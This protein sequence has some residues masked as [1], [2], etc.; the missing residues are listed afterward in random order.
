MKSLQEKFILDQLN[1]YDGCEIRNKHIDNLN[2]VSTKTLSRILN[3]K[4]SNGS[5]MK[6]IFCLFDT[7][8]LSESKSKTRE[9]GLYNL[10]SNIQKWIK[11]MDKLPVNSKEGFV[12]TANFFSPDIEVIVKVPQKTNGNE[13]K[14]REYFIGIK[15]INRLRSLIPTFVYTLGA[16]LCNKSP[17]KTELC[18]N[19]LCNNDLSKNTAF[20]LYEKI[21]G[22]SIHT[23]LK[24]D[25]INFDQWLVIFFQLLLGL[26]VAQREVRFTHFDLHT[27]NVMIRKNDAYSYNV[28]LDM[29]TY[30]II[31]PEFIPVIID[32]G[33]ASSYIDTRYVGSFDYMS[34]GML[35]F[36]IPG[37]DMYKFMTFCAKKTV[38]KELKTKIVSLF[39][40]YEND[41]PYNILNDSEGIDK[42]VIAYC[43]E[44]TF[45][46]VANYT[47][48]MLMNWIWE[49]KEYRSILQPYISI[50][51][52]VQYIPIQYSN[53]I[54]EYDN[55]FNY[56][57]EGTDKAVE[58]I[59]NSIRLKSSYV[60]NKYNIMILEK[61]NKD[62][63][64]HKLNSKIKWMNKFISKYKSLLIF[65]DMAM[66]EKVFDI[67]IPKQI[68]LDK[69]FDNLLAIKLQNSKDKQQAVNYLN[70]LLSYQENL[71]PYLQFYFTILEL[72]LTDT[73]TIWIKK[74][75]QSDIYLFHNKNVVQNERCIRWSQS[76]MASI[77]L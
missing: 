56:I 18:N 25:K 69:C 19:D 40:F 62:L 27:E 46:L 30:S 7:L 26:E 50:T 38:N 37:H 12:Y 34:H 32:F 22:D 10:S 23:L 63:K 77:I 68:D 21:P 59:E 66:L 24:N 33:A 44:S 48:M 67:K 51:E 61:Y 3:Q 1:K 9:K 16:F 58:L 35:N 31:T 43:K 75:K 52:R 71:K 65:N 42:A 15:S 4:F 8:F 72:G 47:P 28:P 60:I 14:I 36:M 73:F 54:K 5:D 57:K 74:F 20:I 64:S 13:S 17:N 49:K 29:S 70:I 41:D 55:I 76:L 11:K 45:S 2:K 39:S 53:I 6:A